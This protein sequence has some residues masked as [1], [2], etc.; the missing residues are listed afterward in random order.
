MSDNLRRFCF[1]PFNLPKHTVRR[2]ALRTVSPNIASKLGLPFKQSLNL[3]ICAS[4]R[5]DV[6]K[7]SKQQN[8][9]S[10]VVPV[11]I[12]PQDSATSSSISDKQSPVLFDS[13]ND[14][15]AEYCNL[16]SKPPFF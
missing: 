9:A 4:C 15:F 3:L 8:E 6:Y 11:S 1:N 12:K 5:L 7:K 14:H 10:S 13:P 2:T 16:R